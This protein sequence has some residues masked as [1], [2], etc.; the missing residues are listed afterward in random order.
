MA[1]VTFLRACLALGLLQFG[2]CL[3]PPALIEA[4][5]VDLEKARAR[6]PIGTEQLEIEVGD[7]ECLRGFFV[8]AGDPA[9]PVVLHLLE[10][11][12]SAASL[13]LDYGVL[14]S[15]LADLGLASLFIDY[16][17]IGASSG[18][19]STRKLA[20]D[21]RAAF[22]EAARRAGG[23]ERVLVRAI[24]LGSVALTE[25]L[26]GGST[27]GG[28]E[29]LEPV[30]G[31]DVV[32]R[33]ARRFYGRIVSWTVPLVFAGVTSFDT[34]EIV[35]ARKESSIPMLLLTPE[36]EVLASAE[37]IGKLRR[38]VD[39]SGG[40]A[41]AIAGDHFTF[42]LQCH[43]LIVPEELEF[44]I[45]AFLAGPRPSGPELSLLRTRWCVSGAPSEPEARLAIEELDDPAGAVPIDILEKLARPLREISR[46]KVLMLGMDPGDIAKIA[47]SSG[48]TIK[49][50]SSVSVRLSNGLTFVHRVD[51]G[52]LFDDVVA[53]GF[54]GLDARRIYARILLKS[55]L[56]PDR[57]AVATDG[58][59]RLEAWV[60]GS[61]I[62]LDLRDEP[63]G[64]TP[65]D[66]FK[67]T[68]PFWK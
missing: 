3:A 21:A 26:A 33:F 19:A 32:A 13:F 58:S 4:V 47:C 43:A 16:T 48:R 1:P 25:L 22:A 53:R 6:Y 14:A 60:R 40:R 50:Y 55:Y 24:S 39:F 36:E 61:W 59:P 35:A 42:G 46:F 28:V 66:S 38:V 65:D 52:A 56:I 8:P 17:G 31:R 20:R 34:C 51:F 11:S 30:D 63:L 18:E 41:K 7:G 29:F 62:Q 5:D 10:S 15:Q 57:V 2:G 68:V 64:S 12:G 23:E 54:V 67:F 44:L 45:H 37:W 9:A 49:S 27:P